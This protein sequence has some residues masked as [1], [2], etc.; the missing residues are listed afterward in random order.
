[1]RREAGGSRGIL[2]PAIHG[3]MMRL[4]YKGTALV[5]FSLMSPYVLTDMTAPCALY[6]SGPNRRERAIKPSKERF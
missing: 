4:H 5:R 3:S 6:P 1:M 2:P